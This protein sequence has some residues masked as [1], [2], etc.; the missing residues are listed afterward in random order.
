M[1]S[2]SAT[3]PT[4]PETPADAVE[5]K[6]VLDRLPDPTNLA[7]LGL[8]GLPALVSPRFEAL[9]PFLYC[10]LFSLWPFV[11]TLLPSRGESPT[12]WVE[13]GD[14]WTTARFLLSMVPLQLNPYVQAQGVGQLLGHL[15]VYRR[16]R[17]DLPTPDS[18]EQSASY[19]L[20]VEGEW[21]VVVGGHEKARSHSWGIL[22]QRYAYDLV[23]TDESGRTRAGDAADP[24]AYYCWEEPVVAPAEGVVV[25]ASDGHRDAPRTRGWV[26]IR[27]RDIRG[28]YAV[29]EHALDEYSVLAH[30]R[31]GSVAV[32]EGDRVERGQRIGLCGHSGNSMEP[33]LHFHVQDS[34]SF[35]RGMGLPVEFENVGVAD[36]PDG[37]P[38]PAERAALRAGQ[39]IVQQKSERTTESG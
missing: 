36:G 18:F 23:K 3:D 34:P 24:S 4:N 32:S 11:S 33:H 7:L 19:R 6:S 29:V 13:M 16:Y 9:G 25:E 10:F 30:L 8:L 26:D 20:P 14:R 17:F 38:V 15:D 22:A 1:P 39:R 31:A 21:T 2:H 28:N 12:S 5:S 27:Q 37:E 35:Y